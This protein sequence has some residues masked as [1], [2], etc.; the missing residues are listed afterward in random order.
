MRPAG[1]GLRMRRP[2]RGSAAVLALG[3]HRVTRFTHFV[4]CARTDAVS[5]STKRMSTCADPKTAL[6]AVAYAAPHRPAPSLARDE[7]SWG[8]GERQAAGVEPAPL[9]ARQ[10][11]ASAHEPGAMPGLCAIPTK[12]LRCLRKAVGGGAV[13]CLCGG[14]ERKHSVGACTHAHQPLTHRVCSNAANAVSVVSYAVRPNPE[15]NSAVGAP[16]APTA[17]VARRRAPARGFAPATSIQSNANRYEVHLPT[18]RSQGAAQTPAASSRSS[19]SL[20]L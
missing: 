3:S 17:A 20:V 9:P 10:R 5:M 2:L 12:N 13:A 14:E 18:P 7:R 4:R 8:R 15:H 1:A 6:L 11:R 16:L 19:N